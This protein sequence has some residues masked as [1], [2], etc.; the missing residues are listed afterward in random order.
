MN[1]LILTQDLVFV[2][3]NEIYTDSLIVARVFE[4]SH[5][6]VLKDIR[7][8]IDDLDGITSEVQLDL[9]N[10]IDFQGKERPKYNLCRDALTLLVMA[11]RT[12]KA[13]EIKLAYIKA[14]NDMANQLGYFAKYQDLMLFK[15]KAEKN[16][17][18][19]GYGLNEWKH[20]KPKIEEEQKFLES[21]IQPDWIDQ[22]DKKKIH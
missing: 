14:F 6:R 9:A 11:Y 4:K 8:L 17:S 22:L 21:K 12:K 13:M 5:A 7:N 1:E 16:A 19:C 3:Q 15:D 2:D 10:Y 20:L 18:Q